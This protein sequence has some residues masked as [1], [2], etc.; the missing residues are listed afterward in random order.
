MVELL[1]NSRASN[2]ASP[3]PNAVAPVIGRACLEVDDQDATE[4]L[5]GGD[6]FQEAASSVQI[7]PHPR[8]WWVT[9]RWVAGEP[10]W[11]DDLTKEYLAKKHR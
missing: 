1:V 2:E 4:I 6:E 3:S 5:S 8:T 9:P 7:D 11:S 10:R